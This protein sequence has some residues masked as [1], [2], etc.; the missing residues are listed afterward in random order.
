MHERVIYT[1]SVETQIWRTTVKILLFMTLMLSFGAFAGETINCTNP[2]EANLSYTLKTSDY[3]NYDFKISRQVLVPYSC[4][5]RW[6][7]DYEEKIIFMDKL[8]LTDYQGAGVFKS[9][10]TNI[11]MENWDEANY[12]YTIKDASGKF[13]SKYATLQCK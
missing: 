8:I 6:G 11:T 12:A 2:A 3:E 10:R 9:K 13:V 1:H 4:R 7:C 5:S